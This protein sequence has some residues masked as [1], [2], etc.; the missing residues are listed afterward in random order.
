MAAFPSYA[1]AQQETAWV[2]IEAVRTLA[3]AQ[4]RARAYARALNNVGGFRT[5]SGWYA[6]ALGPYTQ[7]TAEAELRALRGDGLIPSDSYIATSGQFRQQFWPVGADLLTAAPLPGQT[8]AQAALSADTADTPS[9]AAAPEALPATTELQPIPDETPREAR[10][11]ERGLLPRDRQELQEALKWEGVYSGSIDG[12]FGPGTRNAMAAWQAAQGYDATGVLTTRQ[13]AE[14]VGIYRDAFSGLGLA[15]V[16]DDAAGIEMILPAGKVDYARTEAPFVHYDSTDADGVRVLLI[17][18]S[19]SEATL[20]GLYDIMQTLEIVPLNGFRQRS[21]GSFVLTG[22]SATMH[23]YTYAQLQD[24]AVKGF[25]LIWKPQNAKVMERVVETMRQSFTPIADV[26]LPDTAISDSGADQQIDLLAGLE[27]RRPEKTRS[28]FYVDTIG[29]VLTTTDVLGQ[30]TRLT[31]GE[32]T[33]AEIAAQDAAL[34]LALLR[35]SETLA[36]IAI[37]E[38]R[39]GV[40]RLNSEVALA[41]FSYEDVLDLPV[42]TYGT[43]ADTRGLQGEESV[44]RLA[45][46][47]LPGDAGGPVFDAT[48]AVL[49]MLK[50]RDDAATRRLPPDVNFAI[51]VPAIASFLDQAGMSAK[52]SERS[53][54]LAPEDLSALAGD[55]TVRVSCW[56]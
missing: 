52:A 48:G 51:D 15:A 18:Q 54:A 41:G 50:A 17:S 5:S 38:F 39:P 40:P 45:L 28:G 7:A 4:E 30:C 26:V 14:L 35:P 8:G 23:S 6:V 10:A 31:I 44:D 19:G 24:G 56:N 12:A 25:T 21:R 27:L 11:S 22:Q 53:A 42:V 29:T 43:L 16:R 32:E 36:P 20:F 9:E 33:E 1:R 47:S 55:L 13:R 46:S 49:G 37:A 3:L 34:G 2:Q